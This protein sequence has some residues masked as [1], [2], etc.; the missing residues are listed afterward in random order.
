ML[1]ALD[2]DVDQESHEGAIALGIVA[3]SAKRRPEAAA[4]EQFELVRPTF[5]ARALEQFLAALNQERHVGREQ[6]CEFQFE[7]PAAVGFKIESLNEQAQH[8]FQCT[9]KLFTHDVDPLGRGKCARERL[10]PG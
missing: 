9:D 5:P 4:H 3:F 1:R 10:R 7:R 2:H 8:L 6:L